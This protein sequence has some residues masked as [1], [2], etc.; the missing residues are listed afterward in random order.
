M[1]AVRHI[2]MN[3]IILVKIR[4]SL[5][6]LLGVSPEHG[7]IQSSKPGEDAGDGATGHKLHEDANHAF[8]LLQ[9]G[10]KISVTTTNQDICSQ[11]NPRYHL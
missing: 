4:H 7:F 5:K 8:L 1:Y 6:D 3:D 10:A 9:T 2:P 11:N